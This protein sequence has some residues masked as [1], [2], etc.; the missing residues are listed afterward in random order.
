MD[1][2]LC[3]GKNFPQHAAEMGEEQPPF[4]VVFSK[5]PS[6]LLAC[7]ASEIATIDLSAFEVDAV[8]HECEVVLQIGTPAHRVRGEEALE[9][10]RA[11]TVGL[12]LT[13]RPL[14][15]VAKEKGHPWALAKNFPQAAIIGPF[16][17]LQDFPDFQS[18]TFELTINNT[19]QQSS[20]LNSAFVGAAEAVASLSQ[21]FPLLEGDLVFMGTPPGVGPLRHG[22]KLGLRYGSI[23]YNCQV[24]TQ[25]KT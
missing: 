23:N 5:F 16:V 21:L 2:I 8:H 14:Q 9:H 22:Q 3:L 7:D 13:H 20:Q 1:K 11:V 15:R 24:T 19:V 4:P 6:T 18:T 17:P 10:V 25:A 12:D